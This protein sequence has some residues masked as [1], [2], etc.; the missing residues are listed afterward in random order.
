M[1]YINDTSQQGKYTISEVKRRLNK[2]PDVLVT[3]EEVIYVHRNH[4]G[5]RTLGLI[6][7]LRQKD[8]VR[9]LCNDKQWHQ[10]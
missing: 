4:V 3:N 1:E 10:L 5:I 6:D 8:Y 7:F 9:V 2:H